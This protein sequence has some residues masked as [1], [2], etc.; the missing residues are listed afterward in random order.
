MKYVKKIIGEKC[1]LSPISLDD[2]DLYLEW[3]ND[4]EVTQYLQL[5]YQNINRESEREALE[6]LSRKHMYGIVDSETD[7]LI[8]NCGLDDIDQHNLS[9]VAGIFIG[10][11]DYHGKGFGT[12]A[13]N[14]LIDFAFQYLNLNNIMLSVFPDNPWALACY[15]KVGFKEIGVRR[16][17]RIIRRQIFNTILMDITPE[18]FYGEK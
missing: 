18:D 12:E 13:F 15:K 10:R 9:A 5:F 1:Y 3:V 2:V 16:N 4:L 17:S 6:R 7:T 11:K 14:L 8:G